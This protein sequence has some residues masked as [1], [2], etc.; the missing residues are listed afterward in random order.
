MAEEKVSKPLEQEADE[1][2][3]KPSASGIFR[4]ALCPGSFQME[5][6]AAPQPSSAIAE[7]GTRIHAYME[8]DDV[9]L[10]EEEQ[11]VANELKDFDSLI[12]HDCEKLIRE[13]RMWYVWEDGE[14]LFSGKLDVGGIDKLTGESVVI[15]Y[16]TGMGQEDAKNNWQAMAESVLFHDHY[17][18]GKPVRYCFVQPESPYGKMVC[19]VFTLVELAAAR[20]KLLKAISLSNSSNAKLYPSEKACKWCDAVSFCKA[21]SW[22]VDNALGDD[23]GPLADLEAPDRANILATLKEAKEKAVAAYDSRAEEARQLLA[24]D[25]TSITGWKIRSGRTISRVS[26]IEKAFAV[27]REAG[28]STEEFLKACSVT[29]GRFKKLVG[30]R[31]A[32]S[33]VLLKPGHEDVISTTQSKPSLMLS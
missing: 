26:S 30:D 8:G 17:N 15:N 18:P 1:R 5:S 3:G 10:S 14:K 20:K 28:V 7:R 27:A 23:A 12:L 22:T 25:S 11:S 33:D 6:Q 4:I 16:K 31:G 13:V 32:V 24:E 21:A 2:G 29:T 9:D 19:H